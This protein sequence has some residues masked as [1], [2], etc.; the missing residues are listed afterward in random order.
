MDNKKS[1]V[2]TEK[3]LEKMKEQLKESYDKAFKDA[4]EQELIYFYQAIKNNDLSI[5]NI[6]NAIHALDI[7]EKINT[8]IEA[9]GSS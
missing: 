7:A 5:D 8:I 2:N 6:T 1:S 9:K 3:S 4:L